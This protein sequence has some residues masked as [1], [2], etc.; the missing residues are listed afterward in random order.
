MNR[1][2]KFLLALLL[3]VSAGVAAQNW[4]P[5]NL[6]VVDEYAIPVY[7]QLSL[8]TRELQKQT[9]QFCVRPDAKQLNQTLSRYHD[10]MDSWQKAQLLRLGPAELFMRHF[11]MEMW[12]DRHN[13]GAKQLRKLRAEQNMEKLQAD[14]FSGASIAV[15]GLP[16]M[17]RLLFAQ[18]VT[19]S[20]FSENGK[21]NYNCALL[22]A[23]SA[24]LAAIA[25]E[26]LDEWQG[27]YRAA[28]ASPSEDNDY[29]LT[30][31]EAAGQFLNQLYTQLQFITD[32]KLKRPL[33]EKRFRLKRAESWR[34]QR[35]LR[36]IRLNLESAR[37]LYAI[38]F[39]PMLKDLKLKKDIDA[40]FENVMKQGRALSMPLKKAQEEHPEALAQ[41]QRDISK[42]KRSIGMKL[43][44][45]LEL[46]LG[47]NSLDG[48]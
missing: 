38:A 29:F 41:W 11:R 35:S 2:M 6:Q 34:S 17:E 4:T 10:V 44:N 18:G 1:M 32:Q 37:Q 7:Q 15:Q 26:L 19:A 23:I 20:D 47:F 46:P 5:A 12:P 9:R 45:A 36:N 42:L 33:G 13:T 25:G 16:A 39:A 24:N 28:I 21:G 48:D 3:L 22:E 8:A 27:Q 14:N 43:P 31:K 40:Q 30:D